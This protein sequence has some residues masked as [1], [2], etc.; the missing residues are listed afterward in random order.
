[1]AARLKKINQMQ[2]KNHARPMAARLKINQVQRKNRARPMA[3]RLKINQV[4]S[5]NRA[6]PM[7]ARLKKIINQGCSEW[8]KRKKPRVE[9]EPSSTHG[10][11]VNY[12]KIKAKSIFDLWPRK[13]EN[14][15]FLLTCALKY[16]DFAALA[17][18]EGSGNY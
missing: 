3:A 14:V 18:G 17:S 12:C 9:Q 8:L 16:F 5:K 1:M 11:A 13:F 10:R 7:A 15:R 4:Q 6:R 2:S